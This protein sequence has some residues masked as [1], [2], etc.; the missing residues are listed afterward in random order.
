[1]GDLG[2]PLGSIWGAPEPQKSAKSAVLSS[3][4]KVFAV[5]RAGPEN[6]RK[7]PQKEL[8]DARAIFSSAGPI[9]LCTPSYSSHSEINATPIGLNARFPSPDKNPQNRKGVVFS[10]LDRI[11]N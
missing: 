2:A 6:G 11:A 8:Q 3:K 7:K 5:W 10:K 9:S 4:I 1:M